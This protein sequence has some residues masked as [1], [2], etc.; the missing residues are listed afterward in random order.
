MV[1]FTISKPQDN[2]EVK[3]SVDS[4]AIQSNASQ[5]NVSTD[6]ILQLAQSTGM[7]DAMHQI[8]QESA[9][10]DQVVSEDIGEMPDLQA[11][12]EENE[13][14]KPRKKERL[15]KDKEYGQKVKELYYQTSQALKER[16]AY[17]L[18]LQ[19][20]ELELLKKKNDQ[21]ERDVEH[22]TSV[23]KHA[24]GQDDSDAYVDASRIL[25][26]LTHER[27]K[28]HESLEKAQADY[29]QSYQS[30]Q[31]PAVREDAED[32][33]YQALVEVSHR[34][35]LNSEHYHDWLEDHEALNPYSEDYNPHLAKEFAEV[36]HEFNNYLYAH[37]QQSIIGTSSYYEE[38]SDL[39]SM[40][41]E[42]K[43]G[44][45]YQ[46]AYA[47][48]SD[49]QPYTGENDMSQPITRA[50][51]APVNRQGYQNPY[52]GNAS[53]LPPLSEEEKRIAEICPMTD[54]PTVRG[55]QPRYLT[56]EEKY[57]IYQQNK[58]KMMGL[59]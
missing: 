53:S 50:S 57:A 24:K 55:V 47:S 28:T 36:K 49:D 46:R 6:S 40:H 48:S 54:A 27:F 17:A 41:N 45:P 22:I 33:R 12:E 26:E 56:N 30:Y 44:Q 59:A 34:K 31:A 7:V 23:M 51:V 52:A 9:Q 8:N 1:D 29:E 21:L 39:L 11:T 10:A 58:A 43:Y 37:N 20:M 19:E 16:D 2:V 14:E 13:E 38:L 32:P 25:S 35:E 42:Q 3:F 5:V 15:K 4:P 18:R